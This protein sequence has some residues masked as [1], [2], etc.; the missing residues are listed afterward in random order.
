MINLND[1]RIPVVRIVD[2]L[3]LVIN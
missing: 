3:S 1:N 2:S